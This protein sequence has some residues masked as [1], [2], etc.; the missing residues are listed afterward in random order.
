MAR[1]LPLAD[2]EPF[3]RS[4][5]RRISC[6]RESSRFECVP[7]AGDHPVRPGD[8]TQSPIAISVSLSLTAGTPKLQ[9]TPMPLQFVS[10]L[11][12][13]T[14]TLEKVITVDNVGG[15]GAVGFT[16][17]ILENSS[18]I[19]SVTPSAGQT[20]PNAPV[21]LHV[22]VNTQGLSAGSYHDVIRI[23]SSSGTVDVPVTLFVASPGPILGLSVSGVRFPARQGSGIA[24]PERSWCRIWVIQHRR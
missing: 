5:A 1:R 3:K 21:L 23:A 7:C 13:A 12:S 18:W 8:Q 20:A 6:R 14:T 17:S 19:T 22:D 24:T 4:R 11:Q 9:A 2:G 16:T 15:G 10:Q